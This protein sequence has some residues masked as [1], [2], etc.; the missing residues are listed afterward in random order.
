MSSE[1][2]GPEQQ[3]RASD[4]FLLRADYQRHIVEQHLAHLYRTFLLPWKLRQPQPSESSSPK[5]EGCIVE[6]RPSD[7]VLHVIAN[8]VLLAPANT[9]VQLF[10]SPSARAAMEERLKPWQDVVRVVPLENSEAMTV[11]HYNQLLCTPAFWQRFTA[12]R[13]L[14]FQAD[15]LMLRPLRADDGFETYGYLGAPWRRDHQQVYAIPAFNT[16]RELMG[17]YQTSITFCSGIPESIKHNYGNGGF[18]WRCPQLM[19]RICSQHGRTNG[20]P[21]DIFYSRHLPAH[22]SPIADLATASRFAVETLFHP[23]PLGC[24][25]GWAYLT[26]AEVS[27]LLQRHLY[28]VAGLCQ[29]R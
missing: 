1:P 24:H 6:T 2:V 5:L 13:V 17:A 11:E 14:V 28:T 4:P 15:S 22:S 3:Q 26:D 10:T 7:H 29:N 23:D 18:S 8:V 12:E 9:R 25:N 16:E 27:H 20:E 19:A 21:E